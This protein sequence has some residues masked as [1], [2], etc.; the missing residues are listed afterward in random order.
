MFEEEVVKLLYTTG[1]KTDA[2]KLEISP[3]EEFGDLSFPCFELA[4]EQRKNPNE[5]ANDI[6]SKMKIP[7]GSVIERVD[8]KGAYVNFF[9]NYAKLAEFILKS[10][11]ESMRIGKEKTY[12]VE[13][14][15][16]N[17]HK[18]FHIGHL[19]N[20]TIGES[21]SRILEFAGYKVIRTNYEGDIGPHVAKCLWGIINL[22]KGKIPKGN[23]G[24]WLGKVYAEASQKIG[25]NP[26]LEKE[27]VEINKKLYEGRDKKL[28]ELWKKTRQWS[29]DYFDGVYK[30][31]GTEFDRLYFESQVEKRGLEISREAVKRGVAKVSENAIIVDLEKHGLGIFVLVTREGTPLYSAKDLGLAEK[32]F[33]DFKPDYITHVVGSEQTLYFKQLFKTFELL[34]MKMANRSYHL[35]YGLVRLQEGKM[36]SREGTV[37]LYSELRDKVVKK[38]AEEILKR[39]LRL[40]KKVISDS[41]LKIGTSALKYQMLKVSPE[42]D[43]VFD[44]QQSLE[45]QGDTGP[46]IQYAY[47]RCSSIL[48]RAKKWKNVFATKIL[49]DEEKKLVKLISNFSR[50]VRQSAEDL[51][52]HYICSYTYDL[53]TAFNNFYERHR[54]INAETNE[55]RDFRLGLVKT[56]KTVLGK[57]LELMGMHIIEKM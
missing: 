11:L 46:Y 32:E 7:K 39:T 4:K 3:Q 48:K 1:I 38:V 25:T 12:M 42:K 19:R 13:F 16:P 27:V 21:L 14:A 18:G 6:A 31:L 8:V 29:L 57:C 5:I 53:A 33:T 24:E 49:N 56:T 40:A 23:K 22:H 10:K 9:F 50:V 17:T 35:V 45:L 52:P 15:H 54:V 37:I 47:T 34:G 36:S 26:D 2:D 28:L 51:R 43:V 20:I 30:E 41:A 44:W 55:L